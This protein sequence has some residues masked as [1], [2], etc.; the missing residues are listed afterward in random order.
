M[1]PGRHEGLLDDVVRIGLTAED[2]GGSPNGPVEPGRHQRFERVNVAGCGAL[3]EILVANRRYADPLRHVHTIE[4]TAD[5]P[6]LGPRRR[7]V[8]RAAYD[9]CMGRESGGFLT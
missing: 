5:E 3:H 1:T 8:E 2:R 4:T 7:I 6:A 9:A